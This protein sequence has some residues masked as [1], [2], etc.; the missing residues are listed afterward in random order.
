M[1]P[2]LNICLHLYRRLASAYPHE[3][4]M[5]YGADLDRLGEDAVPQVW[6][7]YGVPGVVRLL[8]DIAAQL[9][10][11][12][13]VEIRQDV[14]YALRMLAKSP[15]F[16]SVAVLSVAIG[17]G[18]CCAVRSEIQSIV[19]PPQG[20][21]DP[22]ELATFRWSTVS[23]PYFER[24]RDQHQAVAAATALLGPVPFAVAFTGDQGAKAERFY[25]HL[26][27]NE[28]FSTLGVTP[29]SGRFFSL[30]TEKPG[31]PPVV[32]VSDRFWR[33]QLSADPH[34]VGRTLRL[35]GRPA[36]IVGI[37][38][39]D[40]LGIWPGNPADLFVPVTCGI[41][42]V[43]ELSPD[44]LDRADR[45]IFRVV[46][47]LAKG[48]TMPMAEAA[49]NAITRNFD[50]ERGIPL[51]R[52]RVLRLMPAGT[53]MYATPEQRRFTNT[54]DVVL[55]ALVLALVCTN[56]A[57][58]LLARGG[59]RRKEIAV[60]LSVGASRPR[61]VRQLLTESVLL[62]LA[63]GAGGIAMAFW[64]TRV[65]SS[66]PVPLS[67]AIELHCQPDWQVL[68]WTLAI[69]M[70]AGV[71]F[72]LVPALSSARTDIG[73]T[74]KAGAQTPLRGYGRFGLRN[75]FVVCQM[76]ASLMLVLVT[77][78]VASGFL[79][80]TRIDPGFEVANL[81]LVSLDPVRDGYSTGRAAA[82]LTALPDEL[83]R[84][85]GVRAVALSA[86]APFAWLSADHPIARVSSVAGDGRSGQV[87]SEVYRVSIGAISFATL[88]VPL[89]GGREFDRQDAAGRGGAMPAIL[90]QTAARSLFG[91]ENPI[92]RRL[93]EGEANYTVV[94]LARDVQA[95][96]LSPKPVP[97]MFLPLTAG[98]FRENPA[99]GITVLVRGTSGRDTL[100]AVRAKLASLHPDLTVFNVR[101]LQEDLD[102]FSSFFEWQSTIFV[103][104]G[105]F[106]LLLACVG[107]G[108][109][110]AYAVARR[111][112]EIGIRM[113][114]GGRTRQVQRLVLREGTALLAVGSA[115]GFGGAF[116]LSRALTANSEMLARSIDEPVNGP[117]L[118]VG[119]PLAL[120]GMA[121]LA[122]YLPARRATRIDPV[123]SL[124]EE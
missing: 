92:G 110:T 14:A 123:A 72:G 19:G 32:V 67:T 86:G 15:G 11:M 73:S 53:V 75:L 107:L 42:L 84:V 108:G 49:L 27:S 116:A 112:K 68:A 31:M 66:L 18:M 36:T 76:A 79:L 100:A 109:V 61:L 3:F 70:A 29:A 64:I 89:L 102:R 119:A 88:S 55:W 83:S 10:A 43:P 9:P 97:T 8:A 74:L 95:R 103:I 71:G 59:E 33:A 22:A 91:S 90:N 40:F 41:A 98:T 51:H 48:A 1:N 57:N 21:R 17:I 16:T 37:G 99:Q 45:E 94:G 104:L 24:Y 101:T 44:S 106:A 111:R 114:L 12:Y 4:R 20:V 13:L 80:A 26:V 38:P 62:S 87:S 58:L 5:R 121:I 35:N 124:R 50:R 56:L 117:L 65:L 28:Y 60:R 93:R 23:Y 69:A 113:A 30:E 46:F 2:R 81:S 6:R 39:R 85:N 118:L 82:L 63:G 105:V 77:G 47:R 122:C 34:A 115:L 52:D 25:G 54:F 120:A 78:F 96:F 7:Q